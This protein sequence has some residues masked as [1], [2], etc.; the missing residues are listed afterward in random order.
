MITQTQ[1]RPD[2]ITYR[3][4]QWVE[5]ENMGKKEEVAVKMDDMK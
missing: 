5:G 3:Y 1:A 2:Q 4:V